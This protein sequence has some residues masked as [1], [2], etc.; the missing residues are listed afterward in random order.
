VILSL[1][2]AYLGRNAEAVREGERG[3]ALV[4]TSR[5]ATGGPYFQHQLVRIL[6][7]VAEPEHALDRLKPLLATPYFLSPAWLRIDPTFAPFKE[8]PR[9]E[10]LVAGT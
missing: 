2:L 5:D 7:L 3:A 8:N 4:P 1:A 10:R 6:L 9:F